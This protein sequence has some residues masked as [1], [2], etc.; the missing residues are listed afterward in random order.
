MQHANASAVISMQYFNG[1]NCTIL[2]S[3][4]NNKYRLQGSSYEAL[5]LPLKELLSR[6]KAYFVGVPLGGNALQAT[7][8]VRSAACTR[9]A[10]P[11]RWSVCSVLVCSVWLPAFGNSTECSSTASALAT[12]WSCES[13]TSRFACCLGVFDGGN[14]DSCCR[15]LHSASAS[16]QAMYHS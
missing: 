14:P 2:V 5:L 11:W 9:H 7:L 4:S 3:K 15:R 12:S 8:E 13:G 10:R 1:E 16:A 6:L